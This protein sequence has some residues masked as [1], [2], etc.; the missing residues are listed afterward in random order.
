LINDQHRR[1]R[2]DPAG[3][4]TAELR[5]DLAS[6]PSPGVDWAQFLRATGLVGVLR[7]GH[8]RRQDRADTDHLAIEKASGPDGLSC[9]V[10]VPTSMHPNWRREVERFTPD[11]KVLVVG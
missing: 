5:R 2:I 11:L 9:P 8:E 1:N 6:L 10:V 4:S 7:R 3:Q